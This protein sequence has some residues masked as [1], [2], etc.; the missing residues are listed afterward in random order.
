MGYAFEETY[1][2]KERKGLFKIMNIAVKKSFLKGTIN[3]P[4]DKSISHRA[5]M[6]GAIAKGITRVKNFLNSEDTRRTIKAFRQMGVKISVIESECSGRVDSACSGRVDSACSDREIIIEGKGPYLKKPK[7]KID[8]GNSGTTI[9]L[10]A[11]IL[12][13]Q[14]FTSCITG[15]KSLCFRPMR[16]IILPLRKMGARIKARQD[17]YAPIYVR[18]GNLK[19]LSSPHKLEIASAQLKSCVLL[20]HLYTG[21]KIELIEPEKSR[22][23][24][25]RMLKYFGANIKVK[26]RHIILNPDS[27]LSGRVISIPGDISSAAFFIIGAIITK[28]SEVF[29]KKVGINP[30]R[31]EILSVLQKMGANV[32]LD[33]KSMEGG[34]PVA[35]I[36]IISSGLKGISIRGKSIPLIID[37]IPILT[38]AATQARGKTVIR[39]AIELRI[40]ETDRIKSMVTELKKMGADIRELR[41]G[42]VINGPTQLKG[43]DLNSYADHRTAMALVIAGLIAES[44]H[45]AKSRPSG[46]GSANGKTT[47]HDV[48]CINTSSPEFAKILKKLGADISIAKDDPP[49]LK[50]RRAGERRLIIA[51]DG[52]AGS[53]KSTVA[54]EIAKKSGYVYLDTGAMYRALTLKAM[55]KKVN[56]RSPKALVNLAEKTKISFKGEKVFLDN[57]DVSAEIRAP[58]VSNNTHF[59]ATVPGVRERMKILQRKMGDRGGIVAEGRDMGT[60][61]FPNAHR[62]FYLDAKIMVRA[63]RRYKELK[64]KEYSATF[65]K[66]L[67][68][69]IRR[70]KRD[71]ERDIAPLRKAKD[72]VLIDT[73]NMTIKEVVQRC[74]VL[75]N[76]KYQD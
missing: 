51:I 21:K 13:G 39:D 20:A 27:S 12:A 74:Q 72:A 69:T 24:T 14:P 52:P 23:H 64:E 7:G 67:Q 34:E 47:I 38:V 30:T 32:K 16:R 70:D 65:K 40:K 42:M 44:R 33:N 35:D 49:T 31:M 60:I 71:S 57:R 43:A 75:T 37:E 36:S 28:N 53:G 41:D 3:V 1:Q 55:R 68:D 17:N 10:L 9:R 73:T 50:L 62:K 45:S 5:V 19:P 18:G 6:L 22:D 58:S 15:D 46:R 8:A 56:L 2:S 59:I 66:V 76:D 54:K 4:G 48:E 29:I 11:G 61:I 25:E 26:G 63:K